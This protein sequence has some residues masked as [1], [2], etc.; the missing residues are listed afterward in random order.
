[1]RRASYTAGE[2]RGGVPYSA[3]SGRRV[4]FEAGHAFAQVGDVASHGVQAG[5]DDGGVGEADAE[6]RYQLGCYGLAS[7]AS[8][9][10]ANRLAHASRV[11]QISAGIGRPTGEALHSPVPPAPC[12]R[13]ALV[14]CDVGADVGR[15]APALRR[16]ETAAAA[17]PRPTRCCGWALSRPG[18]FY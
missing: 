2:V 17:Q 10:M 5:E 9:V 4:T 11:G 6:D 13:L 12:L 7:A 16:S 18:D 8:G 14:S 1:M 3:A 15:V